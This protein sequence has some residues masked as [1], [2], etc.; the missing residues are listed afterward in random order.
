MMTMRMYLKFK[1]TCSLMQHNVL[2]QN[3]KILPLQ[4]L[5]ATVIVLFLKGE[6]F[7]P[8]LDN[9]FQNTF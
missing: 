5:N 8:F 3:A 2:Q 1:L 4:D 6:Q 9:L 7:C